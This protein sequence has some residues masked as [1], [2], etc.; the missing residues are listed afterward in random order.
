M[1]ND[2]SITAECATPLSSRAVRTRS[3]SQRAVCY[4]LF[5]CLERI[6][7]GMLRL[8]LPDGEERVFT[9]SRGGGM[10][11]E[12]FV[13][14]YQAVS[15]LLWGGDI[16]FAEGYLDRQW[17]TPDLPALMA[18]AS[19]NERALG[20]AMRG[21]ILSRAV[22]RIYHWRRSNSRTGSRRNIAFHYDMGNAFYRYWLDPSMTYSSALFESPGQHLAQAQQAK[23]RRIAELAELSPGAKVLEI[24][25]GWGGFMEHAA[26]NAD[27]T[28]H[29]ITLSQEQLVYAQERMRRAGYDDRAVASITDYRDSEGQ[30][31]AVV[32]IEMLEAVGE[33][34]WPR[35]FQTLYQRL[36]PGACAVIQ[37]IS[38]AD[39]RF[40]DYRKRTDF[41]QRHVFPGGM[42]PSPSVLREQAARSGLILDHEQTFGLSYARTLAQ[43]RE[44]FLSAWPSITRLGFDERFRRLWEYYLCYCE[45]GFRAGTID[46]GIYRFRKPS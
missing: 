26:G 5:R 14:D 8:R 13:K 7:Y 40:P 12:V 38:I 31:D 29:G 21:G 25:C 1:E 37:V 22:N 36:K 42:L 27:A 28:I 39:E 24:G 3:W 45:T 2:Y 17:D 20:G 10:A 33:V 4:A 16:G 32:S 41:I 30:Y 19:R 11:V 6:E 35:Y 23:Y 46:V 34:H 43:W 15:G 44:R 9:G 18:F